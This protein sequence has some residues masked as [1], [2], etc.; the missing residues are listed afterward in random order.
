MPLVA[1]NMSPR[2]FLKQRNELKT[3]KLATTRKL[4]EGLDSEGHSSHK[5]QAK[6]S[7]FQT[8]HASLNRKLDENGAPFIVSTPSSSIHTHPSSSPT[9]RFPADHLVSRSVSAP[10][11]FWNFP[12]GLTSFDVHSLRH[13]L[14]PQTT[15]IA[16]AMLGVQFCK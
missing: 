8:P 3:R 13:V 11:I 7:P 2:A 6:N 15:A 10:S 14:S 4:A 9:V 1:V 5:G 16:S 12:W